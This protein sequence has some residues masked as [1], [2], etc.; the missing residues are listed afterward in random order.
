MTHDSL[1]FQQKGYIFM[2]DLAPCH[3]SLTNRTVLECKGM[4]REFARHESHRERLEYNKG[5]YW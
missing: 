3:N 5:R 1:V 4:A 2:H